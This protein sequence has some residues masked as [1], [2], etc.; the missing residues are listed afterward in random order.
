M[1]RCAV[2]KSMFQ[3]GME[4]SSSKEVE[5]NDIEPK[6]FGEYLRF[7]YTNI[8]PKYAENSTMALL[9]FADKY[10]VDDLRKMCARA[11]NS[12]L[13]NNN[14]IDALFL[15]EKHGCPTLMKSAKAVFG[16]NAKALKST[17]AWNKLLEN[18]TMFQY[19]I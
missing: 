8:P 15:A 3:S 2:F 11:I 16:W 9:A 10:C 14:V 18:P 17:N 12:N 6:A 19:L 4:E 1:T 5:L 7:L 13:N